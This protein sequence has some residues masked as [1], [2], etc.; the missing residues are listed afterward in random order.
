M[1][2]INER[3]VAVS[4]LGLET[5]N[6]LSTQAVKAVMASLKWVSPGDAIVFLD[7]RGFDFH[8]AAENWSYSVMGKMQRG[9]SSL[10]EAVRVAWKTVRVSKPPKLSLLT[11]QVLAVEGTDNRFTFRATIA[12]DSQEQYKSQVSARS[13][14]HDWVQDSGVLYSAT[15]D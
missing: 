15:T 6:V 8:G 10:E 13:A 12:V 9:F 5:Y 11:T 1:R 14:C 3:A 2:P 4:K 7:S